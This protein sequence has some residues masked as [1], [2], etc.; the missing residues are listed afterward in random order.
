MN[1]FGLR[2]CELPRAPCPSSNQSNIQRSTSTRADWKPR[3]YELQRAQTA[4]HFKKQM[5]KLKN[6]CLLCIWICE[7]LW[8]RSLTPKT[9]SVKHLILECACPNQAS[10]SPQIMKT[11]TLLHRTYQRHQF[12]FCWQKQGVNIWANGRPHT[13]AFVLSFV[14]RIRRDCCCHF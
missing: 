14:A 8:L 10:V 1:W 9:T 2:V 12:A 6:I 11:P 4:E 3:N 5:F 7:H 13:F